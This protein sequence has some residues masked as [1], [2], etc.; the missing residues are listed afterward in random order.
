M[1]LESEVVTWPYAPW[2]LRNERSTHRMPDYRT[3]KYK[4]G[5][6]IY[7]EIAFPITKEFREKLYGEFEKSYQ[8]E[9]AK[10]ISEEPAKKPVSKAKA[11]DKEPEKKTAVAR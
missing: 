3:E 5:K 1:C 11:K 8:E 10:A 9:K 2:S 7:R 6:P 4:D